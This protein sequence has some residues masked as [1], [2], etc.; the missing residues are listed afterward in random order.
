VDIFFLYRF[1]FRKCIK[2]PRNLDQY[3]Y[4]RSIHTAGESTALF[5]YPT[6]E[7]TDGHWIFI[8]GRC[9]FSTQDFP[10]ICCPGGRLAYFTACGLAIKLTPPRVRDQF[11]SRKYLLCHSYNLFK[12]SSGESVFI[13]IFANS[14]RSGFVSGK[15]ASCWGACGSMRTAFPADASSC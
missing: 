12:A 14:A 6:R 15:S 8:V 10:Q 11:S 4:S 3:W 13:S 2:Y 5:H 9:I 1:G 7:Y